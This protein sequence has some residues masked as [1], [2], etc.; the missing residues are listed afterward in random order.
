MVFQHVLAIAVILSVAG[1]A[2]PAVAHVNAAGDVNREL[3]AAAA[4][5]QLWRVRDL[6]EA[7][8]NVNWRDEEGYTP[9]TWAAQH[10]H[11]H[12]VEFLI[13]RYAAVNPADRTGY[14]PLMWAAQEGHAGVV[15]LLLRRG[16]N[17]YVT[18]P[19]G[20]NAL[21]LARAGGND[22]VYAILREAMN[23]PNPLAARPAS[24]GMG[25]V[26]PVAPP[27]WTTT[28]GPGSWGAGAVRPPGS[29]AAPA[30]PGW[31]GQAGM[32]GEFSQTPVLPP[33]YDSYRS[34][35]LDKN[36]GAVVAKKS[37]AVSRLADES[38][39]FRA[40]Y[41]SYVAATATHIGWDAM[42]TLNDPDVE[43]G[44]YLNAM[45]ANLMKG[46]DLS[47]A[48][49]DLGRAKNVQDARGESLFSRYIIEADN[50][51]RDAGW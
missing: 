20:A 3:M 33:I 27:S 29:L 46:R 4:H 16:A 21:T 49:R 13:G 26:Y 30:A 51:L 12:V 43:V 25:A 36:H 37:W 8:G 31:D 11:L 14:T 42:G 6:V 32:V 15:E 41:S 5:G 19:R 17:P 39:R 47:R 23:Q 28:G 24:P 1:V 38:Y 44:K 35:P 18:D 48:R 50:I 40:D 2:A 9:M 10:G 45:Y 22:R 7:G 34:K